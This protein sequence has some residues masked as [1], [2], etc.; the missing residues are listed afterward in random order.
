MFACFS[1]M[2]F[3]FS[4]TIIGAVLPDILH[5]FGWS[6]TAAG[7]VFAA[8][9]ICYFLSTFLSGLLS[10]KVSPRVLL[11]AGLGLMGLPMFFFGIVPSFIFHV[12]L[13][14][15]IGFGQGALELVS[16][17]TVSSMEK[18]GENRLM[19]F[20]HAS[21]A[22]G[23][24]AGPLI[25]SLVLSGKGSWF[26]AF[27]LI[28][29]FIGGL[30]IVASVLPGRFF[31]S[32]R[33]R[34]E[35]GPSLHS[36]WSPLL[37]ICTAVV[38]LYV[39]VEIGIS[40]WIAE[41]YVSVKQGNS[42]TASAMISFFWGGLLAGR[43]L[44]PLM[45]RKIRLEVQLVFSGLLVMLSIVLISTAEGRAFLAAAVLLS[46]LG[47]SLVYPLVM[48]ITGQYYLEKRNLPMAFLS[49]AGGIGAFVFPFAMAALADNIGLGKGFLFLAAGSVLLTAVSLFTGKAMKSGIREQEE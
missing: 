25:V 39:G 14:G 37:Y 1:F 5:S 10:R 42:I 28:G 40:N 21:F 22:L 32:V 2:A 49:T 4:M 24:F 13:N 6:Y 47:C 43:L 27:R 17:I 31:R 41:Y 12:A 29:V 23:A 9:A 15:L 18:K 44:L 35:K 26:L 45:L 19:G 33:V 11:L 3:G 7:A 48:S 34:T 20:L 36:V 46:G 38:L 16:N 8:G 30:F